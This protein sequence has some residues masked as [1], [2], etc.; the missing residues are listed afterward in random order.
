MHPVLAISRVLLLGC[1]CTLTPF[2]I[3]DDYVIVS[4]RADPAYTQRKF[5]GSEVKRETYVI[6]E[7]S[8][9]GGITAD[10]SL[11][12]MTIRQIAQSL[13]PELARQ[14]FFPAKDLANADLLIMVHWGVTTPHQSMREA[15]DVTTLSFDPR[16]TPHVENDASDQLMKEPQPSQ[17]TAGR[18]DGSPAEIASSLRAWEISPTF[19][20]IKGLTD[21]A[22][23]TYGEA[24]NAQLLGYTKTMRQLEGRVFASAERDVLHFDLT[25][26]R[27]LIVLVAYDVRTRLEPGQKRKPLWVAH[28]NMRA[29]GT[30][31]PLAVNRMSQVGAEF[32]GRTTDKP[33]PQRAKVR[34]GYATPGEL[35]ILGVE[36]TTATPAK[37]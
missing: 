18:G 14:A 23:R 31:F 26:E 24:S 17:D 19:D 28:V 12:R 22:A 2:A 33:T 13:A 37:K 11:E 3:A 36:E 5:E 10:R 27:Y 9:F 15:Q 21:E 20:L 6:G 8:Y 34:R 7:G 35:I 32:F 30:N 1:A 25:T 29:A 16:D 4:S